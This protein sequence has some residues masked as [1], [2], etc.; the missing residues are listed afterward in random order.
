MKDYKL[1]Q[2]NLR[3]SHTLGSN[4]T[5][6]VTGSAAFCGSCIGAKTEFHGTS[7]L[8][9]LILNIKLFRG[10]LKKKYEIKSFQQNRFVQFCIHWVFSW[11]AN[12]RV[13]HRWRERGVSVEGYDF[14]RIGVT[15]GDYQCRLPDT[16]LCVFETNW[17]GAES[18]FKLSLCCA[19][20]SRRELYSTN[21][22]M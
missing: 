13:K 11:E 16:H 10:S 21:E 4:A 8:K 14:D 17:I 5:P 7:E 9:K 15:H 22:C 12:S 18:R 20:K 1:K 19:V 2:R 6:D 3:A